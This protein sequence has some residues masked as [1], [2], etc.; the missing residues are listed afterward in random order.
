MNFIIF[1]NNG[2][3]CNK[4]IVQGISFHDKLSIGN[5]MS[6]DRYGGKYFL[7]RIENISTREVKIPRNVLPDEV[8]Q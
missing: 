1:V 4:S 7:E 5:P 2:E 6:E 8:Y 3:D